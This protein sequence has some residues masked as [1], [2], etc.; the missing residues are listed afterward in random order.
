MENSNKAMLEDTLADIEIK[1]CIDKRKSFSV[2]AGA[3]SGKTTSLLKALAHV[4]DTHGSTLLANAQRILC[5]TYTNAAVDVI[6]RQL[7]QDPLFV[8]STIHHFIWSQVQTFQ[9]EIRSQLKNKL[10]PERIAK[11]LK[12]DNGGNSKA[13]RKARN[14]AERYRGDLAILDNVEKFVYD[15]RGSRNY[16][17]GRLDHDDIVDLG[18]LIICNLPTFRAIVAQKFPYIFVDEAQDTFSNI[19]DALNKVSGVSKLPIVGYFGD[20][21]QQIYEKRAGNFSGPTKSEVIKKEENYRCS[22][23]V[24][25][26][27]NSF[28]SDR[29]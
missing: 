7:K 10:I 6:V 12:D 11:K 27:L 3:G 1:K 21:M 22:K 26:L 23:S 19:I 14:Q 2:I 16:S 18:A 25:T 4:R 9:H 8:V 17:L 28:V 15:E 29:Q 20:P 13:A 24:I 5:I